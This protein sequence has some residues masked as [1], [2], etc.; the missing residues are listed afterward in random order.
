MFD[1]ETMV[2]Y[3]EQCACTIVPTKSPLE[4]LVENFRVFVKFAAY[5]VLYE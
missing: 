4:I 5:S 1:D 3:E 2:T